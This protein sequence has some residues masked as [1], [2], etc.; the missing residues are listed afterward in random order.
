MDFGVARLDTSELTQMGTVIGTPSYMSPEQLQG[1][2]ANPLSD[3]YSTGVV[4]YELLCSE[5]PFTG[6]H[7]AE[8]MQQILHQAPSFKPAVAAWR[9]RSRRDE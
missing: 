6:D 8:V 3:I 7:P 9:W 4:L 1:L 2:A 5:S